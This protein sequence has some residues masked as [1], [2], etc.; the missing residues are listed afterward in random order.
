LETYD[1]DLKA[2]G[3]GA[4]RDGRIAGVAVATQAGFRRYYPVGHECG[5]NLPREKVLA[6]LQ[7]Q[8]LL[9]VP[10]VGARLQY[11][12]EFLAAAGVKS[13]GPYYDV[14]N[15]EPLLDESRFRY[16]LEDL[17]QDY[18]GVGKLGE[19]MD[20]WLVAKFGK[21][22]PRNNIWRAPPEVVAPYALSDVDLPLRIF[23]EH[24]K[25]ELEKQNLWKL[26]ELESKLIPILVAMRR[27][28]VRVDLDRAQQAYDDTGK[29]YD[30]CIEEIRRLSDKTVAPWKAA[31]VAQVFDARG[32]TYPLTPKT[33][34][35]SV[36]KE[37]LDQCEDP[38]AALILEARRLDKMRGTF[39][40]GC[41][42]EGHWEGRVHSTFNQLKNEEARGTVS[43]RFSSQGPNLQFIPVRTEEGKKIRSMFVPDGGFW[44]KLDWSQIEYRLI[45]HD[46]VCLGLS[47]AEEV[48]EEYRT[49][50]DADFHAKVA[51]MVGISRTFAKTINFGL[52]YG[53]GVVKL[54]RQLG[55]PMSEAEDLLGQYHRRAPF[56]RPLANKLMRDAIVDGIVRTLLNRCRRFDVWERKNWDTGEVL[57]TPHRIPGSR[58]AFTHK[59]LNARIQG[60]A[61]D[62]MKQAM[63]DVWESGVCRVLGV[64]QLTVHDELDGSAPDTAEG[65][66]AVAEMKRIME[67]CVTLKVPLKVDLSTGPNW[68]EAA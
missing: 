4:H 48:A 1:P 12:L 42:L 61:A 41:I 55:L 24:Q 60:G 46:A 63:V 43:G 62:I 3:C 28:G 13:A 44:W 37:L 59:A 36:T 27:R 50:P 56:I 19:E 14:Q 53:E 16:G 18:L 25:P 51:D 58:R 6:W 52:A 68:G 35:P 15:A 11:D 23:F 57:Y 45:V 17:A 20:A 40:Q 32:L 34:K 49:N 21:K 29:R 64:P 66:E 5:E 7:E 67:T 2:R 22:N 65:R 33:Q 30:E 8:L 10:K 31:D 39:L 9:P 38:V 54:S 47:G 26:F